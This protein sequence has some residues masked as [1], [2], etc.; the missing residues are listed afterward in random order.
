MVQL[1]AIRT[2]L[3]VSQP[4]VLYDRL[5]FFPGFSVIAHQWK[6]AP[7]TKLNSLKVDSQ[8][9]NKDLGTVSQL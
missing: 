7:T 1:M 9:F 4:L 2:S 8:L 5:I 3:Q 6:K